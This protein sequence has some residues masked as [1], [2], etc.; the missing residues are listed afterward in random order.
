MSFYCLTHSLALLSPFWVPT[1]SLPFLSRY[2]FLRSFSLC[3]PISRSLCHKRRDE[4]DWPLVL[5]VSHHYLWERDQRKK[6]VRVWNR[7]I[8]WSL[9]DSCVCLCVWWLWLFQ[10]LFREPGE[11]WEQR[12]RFPELSSHLQTSYTHLEEVQNELRQ[13]ESLRFHSSTPWV[14]HPHTSQLWTQFF[15]SASLKAF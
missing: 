10:G 7:K 5:A 4:E 13:L 8:Q 9:S 15:V 2:N 1:C 6:E 14:T 3:W 11:V 12:L